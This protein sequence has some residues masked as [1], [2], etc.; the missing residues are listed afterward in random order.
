MKSEARQCHKEL[1]QIA[2]GTK[3][4]Q[5]KE[6]V[7]QSIAI[8]DQS[9]DEP[10]ND[11]T[12]EIDKRLFC[13][14]PNC[15]FCTLSSSNLAQH[16]RVHNDEKNF[17]CRN[18]N[19]KFRSSSN[20]K[21]HIRA[22]H[23]KERMF[24][25]DFCEKK[26]ATQWQKKSH[27][28]TNHIRKREAS[29]DCSVI[30]CDRSFLKYQSLAAHLKSG[31]NISKKAIEGVKIEPLKMCEN[32]GKQLKGGFK[33]LEQ[34]KLEGCKANNSN[35]INVKCPR[36]SKDIV[37]SSFKA[38]TQYCLKRQGIMKD[39][40][41]HSS[42][43]S[44]QLC[45]RTFTTTVS[46]SRHSLIHKNVKPHVC[47]VCKKRFRQKGSLVSHFRVHTGVRWKCEA[48]DCK[49]LFITKS[50]LNQHV[51]ASRKCREKLKH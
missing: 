10:L 50:L 16:L 34:H 17:E 35:T 22:I 25:C 23:T 37:S 4:K 31:H 11:K 47:S 5:E 12:N 51:K 18:C 36:C 38:H 1:L 46:L 44:C 13:D 43:L 14:F 3:P 42:N 15:M 30:G 8:S 7:K 21:T 26:F 29:Y 2:D 20:L 48:G 27:T 6:D 32:C 19:R 40:T 49:K 28:K 45:Q 9:E 24:A 33:I 41:Y 39:G